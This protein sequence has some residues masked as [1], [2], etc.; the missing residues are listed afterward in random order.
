MAKKDMCVKAYVD[1]EGK[2]YYNLP[3]DPSPIV[4]R[5]FKFSNGQ[6]RTLKP[7][8]FPKEIQHGAMV[9]GLAY[10]GSA[11]MN[12]AKDDVEKALADFDKRI[13]AMVEGQWT[14]REPG[15]GEA[16][17]SVIVCAVAE[18][19]EAQG[20]NPNLSKLRAYFTAQDVADKEGVDIE[21]VRKARRDRRA[22][23]IKL[24]DVYQIAERIKAERQAE[25]AKRAA[26]KP[27]PAEVET[28][29]ELDFDSLE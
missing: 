27:T 16:Q 6:V 25:K 17:D 8:D 9:F 21:T 4:G 10:A 7:K 12:N 28:P 2:E 11:A 29:E 18:Y 5:V 19:M 23:Y 15:D 22:K 3:P 1:K 20:K 26:E 24:N 13:A 14:S